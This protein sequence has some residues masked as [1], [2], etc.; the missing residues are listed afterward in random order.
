MG[1]GR[2]VFRVTSPGPLGLGSSVQQRQAILGLETRLRTVVTEWN[3][4][5]AMA[6]STYEASTVRSASFSVALEP[7]ATE[8]RVVRVA[9]FEPRGI[10]RLF[11]PILGP[12]FR[13]QMDAQTRN[14]K[15][16]VESGRGQ[17]PWVDQM[18]RACARKSLAATAIVA[19][20]SRYSNSS[21][22]RSVK[23]GS[24]STPGR[25]HGSDDLFDR[26]R[27]LPRGARPDGTLIG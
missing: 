14:L 24:T 9:E 16:L 26:R 27:P 11:L 23:D 20:S 6:H 7:T 8:S 18:A 5:H 25:G 4:P 1:G 13:R 3:P 19:W 12:L 17:G 10:W 22:P 21:P 2:L 15:R